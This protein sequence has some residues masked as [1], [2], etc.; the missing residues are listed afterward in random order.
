MDEGAAVTP[1]FLL[2]VLKVLKVPRTLARWLAAALL[3]TSHDGLQVALGG[4]PVTFSG[5]RPFSAVCALWLCA[6]CGLAAPCGRASCPPS[7]ASGRRPCRPSAL[8]RRRPLRHPPACRRSPC[9]GT[10]AVSG[11]LTFGPP[12]P[13]PLRSAPSMREWPCS[14][15]RGPGGPRSQFSGKGS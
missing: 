6:P 7:G 2:K 15:C 9:G 12:W 3:Q 1:P 5:S 8:R 10:G 4:A 13:R 11:V 14:A